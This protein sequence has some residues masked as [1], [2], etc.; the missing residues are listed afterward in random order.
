M[1]PSN[2][3]FSP[4]TL[5]RIILIRFNYLLFSDSLNEEV[6]GGIGKDCVPP[7]VVNFKDYIT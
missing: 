1:C 4:Q 7:Y 2:T 6:F 3:L 5:I